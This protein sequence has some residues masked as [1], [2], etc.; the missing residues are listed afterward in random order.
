MT[1]QCFKSGFRNL[2]PMSKSDTDQ[3]LKDLKNRLGNDMENLVFY[4]HV[5]L[6]TLPFIVEQFS[7]NTSNLEN[8]LDRSLEASLTWVPMLFERARKNELDRILARANATHGSLGIPEIQ[9]RTVLAVIGLSIHQWITKNTSIKFEEAHKIAIFKMLEDVGETMQVR[10]VPTSFLACSELLESER[11]TVH[12]PRAKRFLETGLRIYS[13]RFG[14]GRSLLTTSLFR[15]NMNSACCTIF[16]LRQ[17]P[18]LVARMV[19][20]TF[21]L[22]WYMSDAF[23]FLKNWGQG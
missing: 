14:W 3:T 20:E 17:F 5:E 23:P 19:R 9:I 13:K 11:S 8:T 15:A 1:R 6:S 22:R 2:K 18:A 16:G 10:D 12:C 21:R 7:R 4:V